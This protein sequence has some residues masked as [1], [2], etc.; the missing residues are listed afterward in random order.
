MAGTDIES[1]SQT[2]LDGYG[3]AKVVIMAEALGVEGHLTLET[4]IPCLHVLLTELCTHLAVLMPHLSL[5]VEISLH[6]PMVIPVIPV[7][8]WCIYVYISR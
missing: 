2:H 6:H 7:N 3:G 8:T 4:Q 5:V 1:L